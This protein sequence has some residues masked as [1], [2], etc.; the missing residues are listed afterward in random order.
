M[1]WHVFPSCN[2]TNFTY[3]W[4]FVSATAHFVMLNSEIVSPSQPAARS[5]TD[6]L[7]KF[8]A[9]KLPPARLYSFYSTVKS[10]LHFKSISRFT[11]SMKSSWFYSTTCTPFPTPRPALDWNPMALRMP[12]HSTTYK[13]QLGNCLTF[14]LALLACKVILWHLTLKAMDGLK[15]VW[16]NEK[17][18]RDGVNTNLTLKQTRC[19]T[20]KT[21]WDCTELD[22]LLHKLRLFLPTS[23]GREC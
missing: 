19:M 13:Y 23:Q 8:S 17:D 14:S 21:L 11:S 1:K 16:Y 10:Y 15:E 22:S 20:L 2:C 7:D 5:D 18:N 3:I 4:G 9:I 12:S 6:S